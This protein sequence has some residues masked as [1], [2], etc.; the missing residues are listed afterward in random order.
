[1]SEIFCWN[2]QVFSYYISIRLTLA[3][4]V[5]QSLL[6]WP[7]WS[8][9]SIQFNKS[10]RLSEILWTPLIIASTMVM[11]LGQCFWRNSN[12]ALSI[13][14]L[15]QFPSGAADAD[16]LTWSCRSGPVHLMSS[17]WCNPVRMEQIV[18]SLF[19]SWGEPSLQPL[20]TPLQH[21][22]LSSAE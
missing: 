15:F 18:L 16:D 2:L 14:D 5:Q 17:E 7:I 8:M 19:V 1:M 11:Y 22:T 4:Q 20:L 3:N 21:P 12:R 9:K 10:F 6:P 13:F